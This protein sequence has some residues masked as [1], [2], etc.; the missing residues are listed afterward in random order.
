[1]N[2]CK[3]WGIDGNKKLRYNLI[4]SKDGHSLT[5]FIGQRLQIKAYI[6]TEETNQQTGEIGKLLKL[7]TTDNEIIGT[8]SPSFIQ[9]FERYLDCMETDECPELEVGQGTSKS[10][11]RYLCFKAPMD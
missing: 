7:I 11:R 5:E 8:S 10:N 4:E 3:E 1:M 6:L 9:G 2:I